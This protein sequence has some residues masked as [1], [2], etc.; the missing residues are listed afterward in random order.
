MKFTYFREDD[1][2]KD[3]DRFEEKK[4]DFNLA[5]IVSEFTLKKENF[6]RMDGD[7]NEYYEIGK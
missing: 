6:I 3:K 7:I 4:R 2:S 5:K 1:S